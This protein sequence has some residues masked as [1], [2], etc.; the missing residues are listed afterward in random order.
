MPLSQHPYAP[1]SQ[2]AVPPP[3]HA[4]YA[5]QRD[6]SQDR[7]GG[8]EKR[9]QGWRDDGY[10]RGGRGGQGGHG[11]Y[12]HGGHGGYGRR[13]EDPYVEEEKLEEK[14]SLTGLINPTYCTPEEIQKWRKARLAN[15]PSRENI[16]RKEAEIAKGEVSG[17]IKESELC[18][19]E[20]KLRK[21]LMLLDYDPYQERQTQRAKRALLKK[22]SSRRPTLARNRNSN[23]PPKQRLP[24]PKQEQIATDHK[25]KPSKQTPL[26]EEESDAEDDNPRRADRS[27]SG[28]PPPAPLPPLSSSSSASKSNHHSR[29]S[30]SHS[31]RARSRDNDRP[32]EI[33][34]PRNANAIAK[35]EQ[36]G[37]NTGIPGPRRGKILTP[38]EIIAH[39]SERRNEDANLVHN[40]LHDKASSDRFRHQQNNLLSSLLLQDVYNERN[41]ILQS[42][43]YM[44]THNF[45]Q[46]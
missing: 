36:S 34:M 44:I 6:Y 20:V 11:G 24:E 35:G 41:V 22:M 5:Q 1:S 10:K 28:S 40:F 39:L 15:F 13:E 32:V 8:W 31:G 14:I 4:V 38:E 30:S 23:R 3:S 33:S 9:G 45:F 42:L 21:K 26:I 37:E 18:K 12:G 46:P 43:R 16:A 17:K 19:L 27:A 29:A 2:Q 25:K 7:R